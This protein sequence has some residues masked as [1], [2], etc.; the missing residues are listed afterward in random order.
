MPIAEILGLMA[1]RNT[2]PEISKM[3]DVVVKKLP[4]ELSQL[5]IKALESEKRGRS[6]VIS[7]LPETEP[8]TSLIAKRK[9]FEEKVSGVLEV[10][11]VDCY[12]F[13]VYRM[14]KPGGAR[15]RLVKINRKNMTQSER[16]EEFELRKECRDRNAKLNYRKWVVYRG[17]I[18]DVDDLPN[19]RGTGNYQACTHLPRYKVLFDERTQPFQ[20][21]L[22]L[23]FIS[24]HPRPRF[25]PCYRNLAVFQNKQL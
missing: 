9:D 2:D 16:K 1:E 20:Q 24:Q 21:D 14:G 17:A 5:S 19:H 12:P 6:L 23:A 13:E 10:L 3:I 4:D 22:T 7:G 18:T 25:S 15:P 8:N 11:Q